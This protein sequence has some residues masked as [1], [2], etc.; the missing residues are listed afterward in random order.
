MERTQ[1]NDKLYVARWGTTSPL[2]FVLWGWIDVG[3]TRGGQE[4]Q[5]AL[6]QWCNSSPR[7]SS[8]AVVMPV[9]VA[10]CWGH[11]SW[12]ERRGWHDVSLLRSTLACPSTPLPWLSALRLFINSHYTPARDVTRLCPLGI[13]WPFRHHLNQNPMP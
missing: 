10:Q 7:C 12:Q 11:S 5:G 3:T 6:R 2:R 8:S 13:H 1:D 4:T 9:G